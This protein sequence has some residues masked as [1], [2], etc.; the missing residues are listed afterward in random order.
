MKKLLSAIFPV[1][2]AFLLTG[3]GSANDFDYSINKLDV[4]LN[5]KKNNTVEVKENLDASFNRERNGVS[6]KLEL[7]NKKLDNVETNYIH[8]IHKDSLGNTII[9][10]VDYENKR[11]LDREYF[12]NYTLTSKEKIFSDDFSFDIVDGT[13]ERNIDRVDFKITIPETELI[14]KKIEFI[15]SVSGVAN[16]DN[17][18]CS[19]SGNTITGSYTKPLLPHETLTM[20]MVPS[21]K[22]L[23]EKKS[24]QFILNNV[25]EEDI[26]VY[27]GDEIIIRLNSNPSTG[28]TWKLYVESEFAGIVELSDEHFIAAKTNNLVGAGGVAEFK[29]DA[30]KQG[31]ATI[32]GYYIRPWLKYDEDTDNKVQYKIKIKSRK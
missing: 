19:I 30:L 27:E 2:V 9:K 6:R 15:S 20:H 17:L 13:W 29:V 28:F 25:Q 11:K 1:L 31:E 4:D 22:T 8:V 24:H 3:T 21:N 26:T 12:F 32:V 23:T 18:T 7:G 5:F 10:I 14:R 16:T